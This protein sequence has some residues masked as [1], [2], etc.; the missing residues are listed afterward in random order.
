MKPTKHIIALAK[1]INTCNWT[2]EESLTEQLM[3]VRKSLLNGRYYTG[4]T[5]VSRSGMSRKIKMGFIDNNRLY[6]IGNDDIKKLAGVSKND[7][8]GGCGMDMLFAAQ[9]NLFRSL[10]PNLDYTKKMERYNSL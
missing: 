3:D 9:Y 4:V 10:C 2:S 1:K 6:S 5:S 7:S 8:I